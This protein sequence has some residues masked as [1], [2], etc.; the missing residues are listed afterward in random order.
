MLDSRISICGGLLFC[1]LALGA[2]STQ[3]MTMSDATAMSARLSGANEVPPTA[4]SASGSVEASLDKK[5]NELS[6]TVTYSGL[7]GPATGAH[8]HGPAMPG[9]N[10]GVVVPLTGG[11]ASP[12]KG[13]STLTAAQAADL[14]AGKWYMNVHTTANPG[15]EIRGQVNAANRP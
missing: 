6:W 4:T 7:S 13:K 5:S 14:L 10:A 15:G 1:A 9:A 11:M 2:C 12:M 8:F 3:P